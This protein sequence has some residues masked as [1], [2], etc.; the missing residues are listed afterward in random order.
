MSDVMYLASYVKTEYI[1]WIP[2]TNPL[3]N[4]RI[5]IDAV[6]SFIKMD[7]EKYDSLLSVNEVHEYL[8][9]KNKPLNFSRDP[10][11]RSQDLK[12]VFAI[13]FAINILSKEKG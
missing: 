11:L 7:H 12:G 10:W 6:K 13:N 4:H 3:V 9:Y 5:Y 2:V 8:Y 1:A